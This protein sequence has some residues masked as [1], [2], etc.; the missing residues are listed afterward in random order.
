VLNIRQV[1]KNKHGTGRTSGIKTIG[2]I[3]KLETLPIVFGTIEDV[4]GR[5]MR[6]GH[7]AIMVSK[8]TGD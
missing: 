5:H 4:N 2:S 7:F 8:G 1:Y 3:S 6:K